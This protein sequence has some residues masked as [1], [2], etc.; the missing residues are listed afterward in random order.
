MFNK[1]GEDGLS[2]NKVTYS[3]LI[4][5]CSK[6]GN[7]EKAYELY[8]QMKEKGIQPS[9]FNGNSLMLGFLKSRSLENA[10]KLFD[11]AVE[12]GIPKVFTYNYL[13]S[14]LSE[15]GKVNEAQGIWKK[16]TSKGVEPNV[17]SYNN[18]ILGHYRKGDMDI[19]SSL[20]LK[21]IDRKGLNT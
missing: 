21:R 17:V 1:I 12:C 10:F 20:F 7:M 9:V 3:I 15:K 13:L 6:N 19:A 4:E 14:W 8:T 5:W 2:P 16:M 18:M 11:E